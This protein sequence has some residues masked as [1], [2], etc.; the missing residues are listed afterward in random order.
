MNEDSLSIYTWLG[1]RPIFPIFFTALLAFT[2]G[3]FSAPYLTSTSQAA[4]PSLGAEAV[5]TAY[6]EVV[7]QVYEKTLPSVVR[8]EVIEQETRPFSEPGLASALIPPPRMLDPTTSLGSGFVWDK[9]GHIVTNLHVVDGAQQ[10]KVVFADGSHAQAEILGSDPN[11]DLA[12]LKVELPA[13]QLQPVILGDSN[14]LKVG[15]LTLA[16]GAPFGQEFT[17]TSGIISALG[18]TMKG[19]ENCYPIAEAIQTDAPINPGNSGGPLLNQ[20]G[21]VIGINTWIISRGGGNDGVSFALS[22]R[23]IQE[24]VPMLIDQQ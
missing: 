12:V 16:I 18:R 8:L 11:T 5:V 13:Y 19:C 6:G 22:S 9:A 7:A 24:V 2:S 17:L 14:I 4:A 21:E 15:E 20:R 23:V 3:L 1:F 10:I